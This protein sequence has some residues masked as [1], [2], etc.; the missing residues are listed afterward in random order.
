MTS[1]IEILCIGHTAYDIV[2]PLED[3]PAENSKAEIPEVMTSSGGPA[4]NTAH[5]LA[6]W[7][8]SCAFAGVVGDD[9]YGR[10]VLDEFEQARIDIS[11]TQCRRESNT[12]L[13]IILVNQQNGSR[14]I[15]N[16]KSPSQ[17]LE[18][19]VGAL[20][21]MNPQVLLFDGHELE[22]SL[23][24]LEKFPDAISI[25]DAGSL[26][27][28]TERLA[29]EVDYFAASERFAR[30]ACLLDELETETSRQKCLNRLH[31]GKRYPVIVTLGEKGLIYGDQ[32]GHRHLP[33]CPVDSIDTTGAGDLFHGALAY[34]IF[35]KMALEQ[36]LKF[37][38]VT[39]ALSTTKPGGKTSIPPM[40]QVEEKLNTYRT[41]SV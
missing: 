10:N 31:Q 29:R 4:A 25:L 38:S 39:A 13:S 14:T 22:A 7:G 5:L 3:Y 16:C 36:A 41:W 1:D 20:N 9:D 17:P 27:E 28:G 33:A 8:V 11:L 32:N 2:L 12:N 21:K 6:S 23:A 37:A 40:S 18:L 30:Q 15:V 19:D 24:A 26:R 34:G 35:K